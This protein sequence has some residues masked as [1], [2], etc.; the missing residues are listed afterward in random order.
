M[1]AV[2]NN[3][4]QIRQDGMVYLYSQAFLETCNTIFVEWTG[5]RAAKTSW[6]HISSGY[7]GG[8]MLQ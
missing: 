8:K 3:P 4:E 1:A 5:F 6:V 2:S 7:F